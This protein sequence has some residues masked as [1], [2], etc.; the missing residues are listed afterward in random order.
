MLGEKLETDLKCEKFQKSFFEKL[1][2]HPNPF[3]TTLHFQDFNFMKHRVYIPLNLL[4]YANHVLWVTFLFFYEKQRFNQN[5]SKT[6]NPHL[7]WSAESTWWP[8]KNKSTRKEWRGR[9]QLDTDVTGIRHSLEN[10]TP[11][12]SRLCVD[13]EISTTDKRHADYNPRFFFFFLLLSSFNQRGS[14]EYMGLR[15][16]FYASE[17]EESFATW[18]KKRFMFYNFHTKNNKIKLRPYQQK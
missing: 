6:T 12:L 5:N 2:T 14:W 16:Y 3:P 7:S 11:H 17:L 15:W 10:A 4:D 18:F 9:Q 1:S 8:R 13:E